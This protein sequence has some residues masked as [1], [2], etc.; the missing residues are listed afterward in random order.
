MQIFQIWSFFL[1]QSS[2][3]CLKCLCTC[4]LH[5]L[6][7]LVFKTWCIDLHL[8]IVLYL[9]YYCCWDLLTFLPPIL[10]QNMHLLLSNFRMI[11][12]TDVWLIVLLRIHLICFHGRA[13]CIPLVLTLSKV[14]LCWSNL[15]LYGFCKLF[16]LQCQAFCLLRY[17]FVLAC[18]MY[19]LSRALKWITFTTCRL[20]WKRNILFAIFWWHSW[21][22]RRVKCLVCILYFQLVDFID[23]NCGLG[24]L[25]VRFRHPLCCTE[26][27][28]IQVNQVGRM[29]TTIRSQSSSFC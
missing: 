28:T 4:S 15:L 18:I 7:L 3:D 21:R 23:W 6:T 27:I 8:V 13:W 10:V 20:C 29:E 9:F 19:V 17:C 24:I 22:H 5:K 12:F 11:L 16:L 25:L 1:L 2:I 14:L 26:R